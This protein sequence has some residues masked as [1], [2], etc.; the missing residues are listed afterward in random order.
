[1]AEHSNGFE[2]RAARYDGRRI[3]AVEADPETVAVPDGG[4]TWVLVVTPDRSEGAVFLEQ[5]RFHPLAIE[6]A[7]SENER[8]TVRRYGDATFFSAAAVIQA[9]SE[10][11]F[12]EVGF[13]VLPHLVVTVVKA[14]CPS[15]TQMFERW[16]A[17][18]KRIGKNPTFLVHSILDTI[19]D[20]YF[21]AADRLEGHID[22]LEERVYV[23]H[24][25]A[26][27]E[28]LDLKRRLWRLRRRISAI[29]DV[30]NGMLRGDWAEMLPEGRHY[31]QD[32]YDHALR[33]TESADL[34]RDILSTIL[35]IHLS[36]ISNN[37]N[38][39]MKTMAA[40]ATILMS[41]S[42]LAGMW[43]MN[44]EFMPELHWPGGY[45]FAIT[46]MLLV[47]ILEYLGFRR[48]GWL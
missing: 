5:F 24:A 3:H 44:F 1:M 36:L 30:V 38:S 41:V 48:K 26:L 7:L 9:E 17:E 8:P 40:I 13:F 33:I 45:L 16:V 10:E 14:R 27:T 2:A 42:F 4:L 23:G 35:D 21:P 37:L 11:R 12:H 6:D 20:D 28:A 31:Y 46:L 29:R 32:V 18:P 39:V 15:V 43:G 47:A 19:V 34:N 22:E 25:K